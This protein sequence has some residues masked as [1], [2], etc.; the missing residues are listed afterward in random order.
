MVIVF[1]GSIGLVAYAFAG[2]PAIVAGLARLRPRPPRSDR[3]YTPSVTLA[4][5]AYN[6]ADII[7]AKLENVMSLDYPRDAVE[8]I[9]VTD[10]S[11]DDTPIR[12]QEF[13]GVRVLHRPERAGKLAAMNRA[14][15]AARGEVLVFSDANNRYEPQALRELVAP[16]ADPRVGMVTGRKAIDDG[17]GR[18]LDRAEGLYWRYESA[19]KSWESAIGSVVG[20]AGEILAFRRESYVAPPLGT[21]NEDFVQAALTA[22]EGWRVVYAPDAVSLEPASATI[23]DEATRRSRLVTGRSQAI[24]RLLPMLLRRRPFYAWQVVS[25]KGLRP[26]VPWALI[27]AAASNAGLARGRGWARAMAAAQLAFYTTAV[28]GWRQEAAGRRS[29]LTYLPFYFC[30]M[31]VATLRGLRDF[32]TGRHEHVWARV[33]RG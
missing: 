13:E 7:A 6:E 18:A 9:V 10:G 1:A 8:V 16:F 3:S 11:D 32:A 29:R 14:A 27:A 25:H 17:N 30:H 31:N 20:A 12:A 33:K 23:G 26:L 19:L 15:A 2:Y 24:W 5:L 22:A 28:V 21:M 4:V